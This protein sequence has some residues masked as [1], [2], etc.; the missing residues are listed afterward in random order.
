VSLGGLYDKLGIA[1][2]TFSRGANAGMFSSAQPFTDTQRV[3]LR[4]LMRQTY[5]QFVERV[6]E[7]RKGKIQDIDRVARGRIFVGASAVQLGLADE[8]G[9]LHKALDFA[10]KKGGLPADYEV[11][12]LPAPRS[13]ADMLSGDGESA[14]LPING[15]TLSSTELRLLP[16]V[17]RQLA[18]QE[19]TALSH[20][21][22]DR[23]MLIPPVMMKLK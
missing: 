10:A 11:Q 3:M 16:P 13:L 7:T 5:D 23:L 18:V 19:V 6:L 17:L 2:E 20:L 21:H 1:S 12:V 4:N 8:I 9:G 22:Q 14:V 15:A